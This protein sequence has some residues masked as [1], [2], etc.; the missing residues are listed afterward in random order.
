MRT[1][2][3]KPWS[4]NKGGRLAN[5]IL[6]RCVH[7]GFCNATCPTYQLLGD[8]LDGP[9]G[10]IYLIKQ[11]LEGK[12]VTHKTQSHLDRCLICKAC[13]TTCPSGVEYSKLL[14]VGQDVINDKVK[15]S[16]WSRLN[17]FMLNKMV[18]NISRWRWFYLTVGLFSAFIPSRWEKGFNLKTPTL[19]PPEKEHQ[20]KMLLL[21]GCVQSELAP[22]IN[23]AAM[24]VMDR[25]GIT[26]IEDPRNNNCCGAMSHHLSYSQDATQH[27]R[28]NIDA[29]WPFI[30]DG[31]EAIVVTASGCAP[32]VKDYGRLMEDDLEYAEKARRVSLLAKDISEVVAEMDVS[33]L[34]NMDNN[35]TRVTFH[36]PCSLQHG[37]KINGVVE[38]ILSGLGYELVPVEDPHL[39]CGS[40]GAYSLLQSEISDRL[41]FNKIS[42]L[43]R[44]KPN[45][46]ASANIGCIVHLQREASVPVMHWVELLAEYNL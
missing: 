1:D 16:S 22:D 28:N 44:G 36:A 3:V 35:P 33:A 26:L 32:H 17:R 40:A 18:P 8:E 30:N 27:M 39:C 4:E 43:Q 38:N 34:K 25:L 7:C 37:L 13:E 23:R 15:R 20:R 11:V 2:F 6:R 24:Q 12:E 31:V 5:D 19:L 21:K 42:A 9:R 46:I 29:W 45:F 10:R 41:L 14:E